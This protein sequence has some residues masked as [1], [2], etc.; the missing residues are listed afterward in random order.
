ME[1]PEQ[2]HERQLRELG[3]LILRGKGGPGP[4][5]DEGHRLDPRKEREAARVHER[6]RREWEARWPGAVRQHAAFALALSGLSAD[7]TKRFLEWTRSRP[8][9]DHRAGGSC[10]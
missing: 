1:T 10:G 8:K 5:P 6:H 3:L 2:R 9:P 4:D 7:R